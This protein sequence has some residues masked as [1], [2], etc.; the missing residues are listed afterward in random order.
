M[1]HTATAVSASRPAAT[2]SRTTR[3]R[4]PSQRKAAR[5][6]A[7]IGWSFILPFAIVFL[8]FLVAPLV[9]AFYLSLYTKGLATGTQF[10]FFANYLQAIN[11]P[12][13]LNGQ[14]L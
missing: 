2:T 7:V 13:F 11:D 10:S 14:R 9:Y 3:R 12:S 6:Q 4:N 8:V 5:R 1:T